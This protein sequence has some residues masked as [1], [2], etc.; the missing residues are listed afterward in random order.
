MRRHRAGFTLIELLVV[1]AII[2]VLIALLLPAVQQAREAA[3]RTQC[4]NNMKQIGL[5]NHNYHDVFNQFPPSH[6]TTSDDDR[7]RAISAHVGLLPYID[8]ANVY[9]IF[10]F[11][12]GRTWVPT[13]GDQHYTAVTTKISTYRCPSSTHA[14]TLNYNAFCGNNWH[15]MGIAEYEPIMGSDRYPHPN[16]SSTGMNIWSF[17]GIHVI[18]GSFGVKDVQDG[19]SNTMSFGEYSDAAPGQKWSPYRS[20]QDASHP[21]SM[22]YCRSSIGAYSYGPKTVAF[23]PNARAYWFYPAWGT[24]PTWNTITMAALKSAHT[25]GVHA[26]MGDGAVRFLSSNINLTTYK[27]LADRADENAIGEF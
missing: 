20:H 16:S 15:C 14:N 1:I 2:A 12:G 13:V 25:G 7:N 6:V 18:N 11:N 3:R 17:G 5:A 8:Q 26:L 24:P 10:N 9:N 23:T 4:K 19:T 21:W 27:N 22:G